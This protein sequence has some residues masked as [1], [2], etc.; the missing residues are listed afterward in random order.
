MSTPYHHSLSSVKKWGG[1]VEDYLPI[2]D[3]FDQSK[4]HFGDFRHRALRHHSQGIYEMERAFGA[5][6]TLSSGKTIPTRPIGEQHVIEDLGYIPS[7]KDWFSN[8]Q[9]Q[10]WMS[11]NVDKRVNQLEAEPCQMNHLNT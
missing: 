1:T 10:S 9:A 2:H 6:I 8:I 11:R 7:I 4:E 3:W 5:T